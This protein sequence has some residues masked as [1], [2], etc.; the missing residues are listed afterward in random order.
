MISSWVFPALMA[1]STITD[2][3]ASFES[4]LASSG[5]WVTP[6]LDDNSVILLYNSDD[7]DSEFT[8]C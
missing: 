3:M 6:N 4:S 8:S 5:S 7:C 2:A 1:L